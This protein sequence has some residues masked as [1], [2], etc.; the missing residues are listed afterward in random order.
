MSWH[1]ISQFIL[2]YMKTLRNKFANVPIVAL[3]SGTMWLKVR[4]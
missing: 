4:Q 2:L 1:K 3:I